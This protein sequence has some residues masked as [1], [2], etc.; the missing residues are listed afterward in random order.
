M[1]KTRVQKL[2]AYNAS[3]RCNAVGIAAT[4]LLEETF[5]PI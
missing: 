4:I 5:P 3:F 2:E 1:G